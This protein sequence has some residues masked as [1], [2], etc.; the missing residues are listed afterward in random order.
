MQ[1]TMT[2]RWK[3]RRGGEGNKGNK[4]GWKEEKEEDEQK[5]DTTVVDNKDYMEG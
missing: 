4:L 5:N 2:W 3:G 1:N